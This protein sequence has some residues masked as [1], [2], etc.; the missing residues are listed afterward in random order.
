MRAPQV[1]SDELRRAM[2]DVVTGIREAGE[3]EVRAPP[4]HPSD[5]QPPVPHAM[6]R[7]PQIVEMTRMKQEQA[8][9]TLENMK[10]RPPTPL[11]APLTTQASPPRHVPSPQNS[12][13]ATRR[14]E[15]SK[16]GLV[17]LDA[18]YGVAR[19]GARPSSYATA[20]VDVTVPLQCMVDASTLIVP[21]GESK[22]WLPGFYD[23]RD[24]ASKQLWV[25]YEFRGRLHEVVVGDKEEMRMPMRGAAAADRPMQTQAR[26]DDR[27]PSLPLCS[28]PP[29]GDRAGER[30]Q[31]RATCGARAL[32]GGGEAPDA[33]RARVGL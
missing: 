16:G 21:R 23:P 20:W 10:V 7:V 33:S 5:A 30:G 14:K 25:L 24:G 17:V 22:S 15:R 29:A 13:E 12:F 6:G 18:V 32:R 3:S 26:A 9:K 4:P 28:P 11:W 2:Y 27:R 31:P 19:E 1:L 8:A